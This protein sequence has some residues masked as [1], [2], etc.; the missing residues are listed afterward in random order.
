MKKLITAAVLTLVVAGAAT[1]ICG[2]AASTKGQIFVIDDPVGRNSVTFTS[3]APLEDIVG[4]SNQ[5]G[6]ELIFDPANPTGGGGHIS[7]PVSSL[8]TGIPTRDGHL[9]GAGWLDAAQYPEIRF[10]IVEVKDFKEVKKT[11]GAQ[12]YDVT[13]TGNFSMHGVTRTIE[14]PGRI[15]YLAESPETKARKDGNL[16]AAR[17]EFEITLADFGVTGPEGMNLVGTKVGES[18]Q[19]NFS[20]IASSPTN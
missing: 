8:K 6:G 13:V 2:Q 1:D 3:T 16:L 15:T 10:D 18:I 4:T 12:T 14:V 5:I 17:A 7:V 11:E 20:V 9:A 19:I